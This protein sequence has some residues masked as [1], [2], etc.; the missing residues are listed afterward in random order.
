[1][2]QRRQFLQTAAAA[3]VA[4]G[5][6][7]LSPGLARAS[8]PA[9]HEV[10]G[11]VTDLG[12]ASVSTPLGNGEFVNGVLYAGTRGL[13][14]N[15]VGAYDLAKDTVT[16]HVD[17]PTGIGVWAMCKV[18]TDVYVGTHSQSDLYRLDTLTG[19]ATKV[20][21]YPYHFIWNL[22]ASPDGKVFLAIS[23]PGRVVE[24]DPASGASRDLGVTVE[25]EAYV[26]SIAAD[27]TTIYA[28]V[29]ANAHLVTI[30][31]ATGAKRDILPA[32]LAERDF[33]ASLDIS[34]THL[35]GGISS[36]GEV[37]V[38]SKSDPADHRII[39]TSEKYI[40]SV[41]LHDGFVYFT[42]RPSGT[43]YRCSLDGGEVETLGIGAPE[44][45]THRLLAHE[46]KVY[47]VQDGAV[48]VFDPATKALA[49][50][51]LVQRGFKAAPE[52]PMSV[53]SDGRRVY[54]GGKGG[55]DIHDIVAKSRTR[56]GIPGEPKTA[57]TVRDRTYLGVYTQGLLY[58]HR[59][60]DAEA[61]LLAKTGNQQDRPR[62]LAYDPSTDLIA[63][64]TQPEP[65]QVNGALSL[66]S[67]RT[68]KFE[69]HRPLV[70]RQSLYAV[71]CRRG[72]AYIGTNIQ[73]GLGLPPVTT[74]AR[75]AAYDLRRRK[76]LWQV[77]P[78]PGAK[79]VPGI[80]HTERA[81]Y[82]VTDAGVLF[83]FDLRR[84]KVTRT[85]KVGT[86]G[87]DLHI[88]GRSA[89]TTDGQ[90][91]Y[92]IDLAALTVETIAGG[93]AGEWFGGEPKLA[94]DP[95]RRALYGVKGRNL[96]RIAITG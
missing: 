49:Y 61:K 66:Y 16:A 93:L 33:V 52:Q 70:E 60:G 42:G 21:A 30:D 6:P 23:E 76:L 77:E 56:L 83:E 89:Y 82:G 64:T 78:V 11:T 95:S 75:L 43:L 40:P 96:V 92:K 19:S 22:A 38:M 65:G 3:A 18:G 51:S 26:R 44:A 25:G 57:L 53:H 87:S 35:A 86:R 45:A 4:S 68:G 55:A 12:P 58:S 88:V 24:Y 41:L 84:R 79:V 34:G 5:T 71:T 31:R 62:D 90:A 39:T 91:V 17:I 94:L 69:T 50:V 63:M 27:E 7:L 2:I 67:P 29:G 48:L 10:E 81:V 9:P 13:S 1:M 37:L 20:G 46:G 74:T 8:G 14:P 54:V 85:V 47:G 59:P 36:N 80:A 28:G 72:V 32:A 15:V 73:E